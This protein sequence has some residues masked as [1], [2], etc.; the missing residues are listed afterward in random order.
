M[1]F[2]RA[3]E[4]GWTRDVL[5]E[6][7]LH[8]THVRVV[9]KEGIPPRPARAMIPLEAP[10][11][12]VRESLLLNPFLSPHA[13]CHDTVAPF[14]AFLPKRRHG[15][16]LR[17][18]RRVLPKDTRLTCFTLRNPSKRSG[19]RHV[20]RIIPGMNDSRLTVF[21]KF[22]KTSHDSCATTLAHLAQ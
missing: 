3:R 14:R 6:D 13:R 9:R 10:L 12:F 5:I 19:S 7:D 22:F 4:P 8:A 15:I 2:P 1:L 17:K 16:L 21:R 11:P 20:T 18:K